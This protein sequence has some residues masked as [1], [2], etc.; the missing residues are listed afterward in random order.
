MT[1][2]GE[3]YQRLSQSVPALREAPPANTAYDLS[4]ST[5]SL[6]TYDLNRTNRAYPFRFPASTTPNL[7]LLTNIR[8][9]IS[10]P[11]FNNGYPPVNN[12]YVP[13]P[14]LSPKVGAL[15]PSRNPTTDNEDFI[16]RCF[17]LPDQEHLRTALRKI[18]AELWWYNN[19]AEPEH[20]FDA[21]VWK[22]E[23]GNFVCMICPRIYTRA[24]RATAHIRKHLD[25]RPFV[26]N[27]EKCQ[28]GLGKWYETIRE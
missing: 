26:C 19:R 28:A 7:S 24:D 17:P 1:C 22:D 21:L 8:S 2:S 18:L 23:E 25:H 12:D 9:D 6:G 13:S 11:D 14:P 10:Y 27:G 5:P 3:L 20:A 15:I 16:G 4:R